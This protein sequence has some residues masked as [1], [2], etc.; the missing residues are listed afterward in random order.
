MSRQP[1]PPEPPP[2]QPVPAEPALQSHPGGVTTVDA[3]YVRP[4]FASIHVIER[5]GRAA[6][7]DT[8]ANSSIPGLQRALERLGIDRALVDLIFLTHVHLDHA[9]GAGLLAQQL[10]NARVVVHPRGVQHLVDPSRLAQATAAVYGASAFEQLYGRLVPIALE[11]IVQT[12]DGSGLRLGSSELRVLHT[13][14]HALHHQVLFDPL[15]S[16]LFSGDTLGLA[17]PALETSAG[18]FL[19][20]TTSPTQFDPEQLIASIR[21][22]VA[23]RPGSVYLTHYGR[24]TAFESCAPAL[25]EQIRAFV[26]IA[27]RHAQAS[28]RVA[29]IRQEL[30]SLWL[31][32]LAR[33]GA[34]SIERL[35][36]DWLAGDLELNAEGLVAWLERRDKKPG[37][38]PS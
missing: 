25:E 21:K 37:S 19:V 9:G 29:R 5:D 36:D 6:I 14:G 34:S 1:N 7:V 4:G 24:I 23:L 28:D 3:L 26:A 38:R 2:P 22:L 17:Y 11:R 33:H 20:P 12:S 8:G 10:P 15:T 16:A 32:R 13:P 30:R 27:L 35:V 31:E 18:P